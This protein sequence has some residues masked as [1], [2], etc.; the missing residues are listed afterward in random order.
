MDPDSSPLTS[1]GKD[2]KKIGLCLAFIFIIFEERT[3]AGMTVL[4]GKRTPYLFVL[5][6]K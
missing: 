4:N 1:Q 6:R 2:T 5:D 3:S